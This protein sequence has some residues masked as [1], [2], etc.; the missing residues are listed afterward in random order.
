MRAVPMGGHFSRSL[1]DPS[2]LD[3][4]MNATPSGMIASKQSENWENVI[5][6]DFFDQRSAGIQKGHE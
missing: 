6:A 4:A 3:K 1:S 5:V 2:E